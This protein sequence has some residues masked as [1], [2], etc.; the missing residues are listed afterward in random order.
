VECAY[1]SDKAY[2]SGDIIVKS[3]SSLRL[4][5]GLIAI[6][7]YGVLFLSVGTANAIP[8]FARQTG[9][10][11]NRCHINPAELT[12]EG[13]KF[14]LNAY[15]QTNQ[16]PISTDPDR[17]KSGLSLLPF[18]PLSAWIQVSA[19][20]LSKPQPATQNWNVSLPQDISLFLAG[21]FSS[22][23]G[24]FIQTIFDAQ[25]NHFSLDNTD[26]RYARGRLVRG[27]TVVY[28]LTLNNNPT[29]EDLWNSTPA[30]GF[31][32]IGPSSVPTP[33]AATIVDGTL[34]QDVAGVGAY[35]MWNDHLYGAVSVYRSTHL[36]QPLPNSGTASPFN[37]QGVAPYWRVAWEQSSGNN[38]LEVGAYG[39]HVS[40]TPN[41]VAGLRDS[42][43]DVAMDWQYERTL[44]RFANDI[45][46]FHG[47]FIH[48]TS[49]LNATFNSGAAGAVPHHLN[50]FRTDV[51]YHAG[52][53][54]APAIGYFVTS[55]TADAQMFAPDPLSGSRTGSPRGSGITAN[56]TYWPVMNIRLGAQ[57]THYLSFNGAASNYDGSGRNAHDNNSIYLLA[58]FVF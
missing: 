51:V 6:A 49:N 1:V 24:G 31:P 44:P 39:M 17:Q 26:I 14:K 2:D 36:G 13:R 19:T 7:V 20:G 16:T 41:A 23:S 30:W 38:D 22:H 18:L 47:T 57:Y 11:C 10:T 56:L 37:I 29:V 53:R 54:L 50:T 8:S 46:T 15:T 43:T 40:S 25:D 35:T 42:Y 34:G 21:A 58:G 45:L 28:G 3:Y 5:L 52:F 9:Y 48:E 4:V 55:G 32:W 12:D 33:G 27:K